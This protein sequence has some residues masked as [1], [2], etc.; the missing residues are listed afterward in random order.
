MIRGSDT[1]DG[2]V[3]TA[4]I[5]LIPGQYKTIKFIFPAEI[6]KNTRRILNSVIEF[7]ETQAD[8]LILFPA[9]QIS[10]GFLCPS[11]CLAGPSTSPLLA[12]SLARHHE[13]LPLKLLIWNWIRCVHQRREKHFGIPH[14]ISS[15]S[16]SF[17]CAHLSRIPSSPSPFSPRAKLFAN[18]LCGRRFC[19]I[20]MQA[21][22]REQRLKG[23]GT[24]SGFVVAYLIVLPLLPNDCPYSVVFSHDDI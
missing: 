6:Q 10:L 15:E 22:R 2:T 24:F 17:S 21:F 12:R 3:S 20:K 7:R 14:K 9:C 8:L 5:V 19:S 1:K 11:I 23:V 18:K 4:R 13:M 16:H